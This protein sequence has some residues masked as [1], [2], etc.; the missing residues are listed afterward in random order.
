MGH[1]HSYSGIIPNGRGAYAY[2]GVPLGGGFDE[3]GQKGVIAGKVDR[4]GADLFFVP[5]EGRQYHVLTVPLEN[6]K[7]YEGIEEAVFAACPQP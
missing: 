2:C 5:M 1:V 7:G 3:T 6:Q 4:E